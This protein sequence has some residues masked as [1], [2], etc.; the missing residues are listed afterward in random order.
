MA[1]KRKQNIRRTH[2]GKDI[3]KKLARANKINASTRVET[4]DESLSPF[5]GLLAVVK[6]LEVVQFQ[7]LFR[8][9]YTNPSRDPKQGH[10]FMVKGIL[11]LLFI[12]FNRLWHFFYIR[13]D[14]LICGIFNVACLPVASTYW[15]YLDSMG[16]N[17][18]TSLVNLIAGLRKRMWEVCGLAYTKVQ[19]VSTRQ[20]RRFTGTSRAPARGTV[21]FQKGCN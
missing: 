10:Y 3:P 4:C 7:E 11:M 8:A 15:R 21:D 5:G 6:F 20:W 19:S 14:P 17:Q 2:K 18:A 12:G 16:I 9:F 13:F 1:K